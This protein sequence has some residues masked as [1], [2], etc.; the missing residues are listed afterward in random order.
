[1]IG[2]YLVTDLHIHIQPWEMLLPE[3]R[4]RME[5]GRKDLPAIRECM[6]SPEALLKFL[7][8]SGIDR[9]ALINYTSP[10]LM[11]FTDD[12]NAWCARYC[13]T[14]PDRLVPFGSVHPR[15]SKDP[16]GDTHRILDLGI[17]GLKVHPP[18]QLFQA[19]EYR[20]GGPGAGIGE[21]YRVAQERKVPVM[22][23][24]GTSVFPG[25]RNTYADPMPLDDVAVDFPELP[26]ILAHAGRPL[27][28]PTAFFLA[29]RHKNILLDLSGIPPARLLEYVPRLEEVA[30]RTLWGSDWPGPGVPDMKANVEAF[31]ALDLPD[32]ARRAILHGNA[33][34]LFP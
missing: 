32:A 6:S 33:L 28:G 11:G 24:T 9:V 17:R 21:V 20:T 34:R 25:A 12:V 2:G 10:D 23:H 1:M 4:A 31:L 14:A 16:A 27:H 18:H 3:V 5:R 30:E 22:F 8:G 15:F 13:A 29:R 7:D 26:M 19:N